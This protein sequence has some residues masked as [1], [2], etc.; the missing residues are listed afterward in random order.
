MKKIIAATFVL[1]ASFP[2][3]VAA[4]TG[5]EFLTRCGSDDQFTIGW[6]A[7]HVSGVQEGL[8]IGA[9][10]AGAKSSDEADR[11]TGYCAPE[12]SNLEQAR[13]I[14]V[15]YIKNHPETRHLMSGMLIM[16]ALREAWPCE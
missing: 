8:F 10:V 1:A 16:L 9:S 14:S 11:I 12:S 3:V 5:N 7:G 15:S 6:C 13:D 4:V 2:T